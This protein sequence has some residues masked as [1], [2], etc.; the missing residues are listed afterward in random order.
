[1]VCARDR[2]HF[3]ST[4]MHFM[5]VVLRQHCRIAHQLT[6]HFPL[7]LH[8]RVVEDEELAYVITRAREVRREVQQLQ[9]ISLSMCTVCILPGCSATRV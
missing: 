8:C 3:A 6:Q 5:P 4:Y 9:R 2:H 7:L 1:M